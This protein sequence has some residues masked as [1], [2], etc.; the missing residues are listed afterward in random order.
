MTNYLHRYIEA[1]WALLHSPLVIFLVF[2]VILLAAW[3]FQVE[4]RGG[5]R[6]K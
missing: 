2:L 1:L 6:R 4:K 5:W 3:A